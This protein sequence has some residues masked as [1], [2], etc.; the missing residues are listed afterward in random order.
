[1]RGS[2]QN[3]INTPYCIYENDQHKKID[4]FGDFERETPTHIGATY[5]FSNKF[6]KKNKV[7]FPWNRTKIFISPE[8]VPFF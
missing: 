1:M 8:S 3:L 5:A 6:E 2:E 7:G 4:S